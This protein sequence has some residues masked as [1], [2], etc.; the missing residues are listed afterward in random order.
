[1]QLDDPYTVAVRRVDGNHGP[2][3]TTAPRWLSASRP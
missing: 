2:T 3:S 1:M